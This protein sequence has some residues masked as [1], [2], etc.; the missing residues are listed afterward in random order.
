MADIGGTN[1]RFVL[2][3][4]DLQNGKHDK[5]FSKVRPNAIHRTLSASISKNI[6]WTVLQIYP[7]KD[8]LTFE[9][10]LDALANEDA[11]RADTP[12]AAAFACAGPVLD[13]KCVM[14]NLEWVID[15]QSLTAKYG[16]RYV[17]QPT[18]MSFRHQSCIVLTGPKQ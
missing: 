14:T 12:G 2:W 7:T 17:L 18:L 13:N 3:R 4:L 6:S 11:F 10:A 16:I 15:G 9:D 5:L 1:C 8:Y